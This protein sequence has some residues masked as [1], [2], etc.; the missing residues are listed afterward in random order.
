MFCPI[1]LCALISVPLWKI[2][3]VRVFADNG[4]K[5]HCYVWS[6]ITKKKKVKVSRDMPSWPKGFRVD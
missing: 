5:Q 4:E 3:N 1:Q 2:L 6:N